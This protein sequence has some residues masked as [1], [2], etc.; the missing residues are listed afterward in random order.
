MGKSR[1]QDDWLKHPEYSKWL[2]R[3]PTNVF[4]AHCRI[5]RR[6]FDVKA[7][8]EFAV[9]SHN[10]G[11]KH[12]DNMKLQ[13]KSCAGTSIATL[14]GNTRPQETTGMYL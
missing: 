12:A 11:K 10:A 8:G 4:L 9:R 7:M 14:F 3:N 5:C 1:F 13:N 6:S 2:A